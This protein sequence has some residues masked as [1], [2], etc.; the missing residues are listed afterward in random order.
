MLHI[1]L[2]V[3]IFKSKHSIIYYSY[4]TYSFTNCVVFFSIQTHLSTSNSSH[5]S[6]CYPYLKLQMKR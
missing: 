3:K 6:N 5:D 1:N 2:R 4:H